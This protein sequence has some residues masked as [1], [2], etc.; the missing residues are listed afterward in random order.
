MRLISSQIKNFR[1]IEDSTEFRIGEV[2]C[3]VGK[4]ESG[5]T[6]LLQ[7]L[8]KIK[9]SKENR[10]Q[11]DQWR[12]Y[13][14]KNWSRFDKRDEAIISKWKLE[15]KDIEAIEKVLTPGVVTGTTATLTITYEGQ[16]KWDISLDETKLIEGLVSEAGVDPTERKT[17]K[18]CTKSEELLPKVEELHQAGGSEQLYTLFQKL[19]DFRD[20]DPKLAASDELDRL[21]PTFLY[22]SHYDRMSGNVPLD[23]LKRKR[24]QNILDK[25]DRVFLAFLELAETS[26][27]DLLSLRTYEEFQARME[28]ASAKI[29]DQIFKYWTQ[30][31]YLKVKFSMD[32]ACVDDPHPLNTGYIAHTRILNDLHGV[33]VDFDD[34]SAG[35]VWFFSFLVLFSQVKKQHESVIILLDEPG[36]SLHA[37]A[38]SDLLRFINE[39]LRPTHQV[40]F[41]T[42]SPF[43]VP[44]NELDAVRTVEDVVEKDSNGKPI[45]R[46]GK[47]IGRGTKVGDKVLSND[48]DTLFPLQG[49]L[50]YE[51]T[52]TLFVGPNTLI[53][54]GPSDILYIQAF[55]EEARCRNLTNL[56]SKWTICPAGGIDKVSAFLSLFSGNHLKVAVL[57]D[58]AHGQKRKVKRF[59]EIVEPNRVFTAADFCDREQSE[60]DIEDLLGPNLYLALVNAAYDLKGE[61]TL[62]LEDISKSGVNSPR[63]TEQVKAIWWL[64]SELPEFDHFVPASYLIKNPGIIRSPNADDAVKRFERF[65]QKLN[66]LIV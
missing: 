43:M 14:R 48:K 24:S 59:S 39:E 25:E 44:S 22:F 23:E 1:C 15:P 16:R 37:K 53:V 19:S 42:H 56:N 13:P 29:S 62:T 6:S 52:Q 34:R 40:I 18:D 50:G 58:L 54:E 57:T 35:F 26:V 47:P 66:P 46:N 32:L 2:T 28:S 45:L 60:A 61:N 31:E 49:A 65:F 30:N 41:S 51:I 20:G 17:L 8:A 21:L 12:D 11:F 10:S 5:K 38:Q 3:L 9:S 33:T 4:N 27:D 36:L 55:S 63:I 7:A 64:K